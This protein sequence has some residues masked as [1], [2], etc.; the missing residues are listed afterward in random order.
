MSLLQQRLADLTQMIKKFPQVLV[1]IPTNGDSEMTRRP[2]IH[3]AIE[4]ARSRLGKYGRIV[5]RRSGTEPLLRILVEGEDN[6][7]VQAQ[8][9]SLR[10]IIEADT[11]TAE[12]VT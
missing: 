2:T 4:Q 11:H 9:A 3:N 8:A 5:V 10:R 6:A 1:N 12:L 7:I